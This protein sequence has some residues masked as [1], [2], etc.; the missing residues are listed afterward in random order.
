MTPISGAMYFLLFVD[1]YIKKMWVYFLKLKY[2]VF[3][4][5]QNIQSLVGESSCHIATLMFDNSGELCVKEFKLFCTKH[6][7]KR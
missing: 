1:D 3:N 2:E 5:F 6:E 7:I 4:E